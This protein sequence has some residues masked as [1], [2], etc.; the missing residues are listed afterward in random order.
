MAELVFESK[1]ADYKMYKFNNFVMTSYHRRWEQPRITPSPSKP[2]IDHYLL[3]PV[4]LAPAL[5]ISASEVVLDTG[6]EIFITSRKYSFTSKYSLQVTY[7]LK[8]Y[9]LLC[10][11][12]D[13]TPPSGEGDLTL[14]AKQARFSG[15][16]PVF[17]MR[18]T[19]IARCAQLEEA[20]C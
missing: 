5:L 13:P 18:C 10:W 16:Q 9:T 14:P 12:T 8:S 3:C 19:F 1:Q 15:M 17:L 2:P 6:L 20:F 11:I 4:L 7:V